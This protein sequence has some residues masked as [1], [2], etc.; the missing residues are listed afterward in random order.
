MN[1]L[2]HDFIQSKEVFIEGALTGAAIRF[3]YLEDFILE[4][5]RDYFSEK[6]SF[7]VTGI[8][9]RNLILLP[10]GWISIRML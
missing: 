5:I 2:I 9:I 7:H 10:N 4:K 1:I 6:C 8:P 3:D